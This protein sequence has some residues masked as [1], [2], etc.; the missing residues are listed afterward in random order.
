M[1]KDN[2][3]LV[4]SGAKKSSRINRTEGSALAAGKNST[5][6]DTSS[7]TRGLKRTSSALLD[8]TDD[9]HTIVC[10]C[11]GSYVNDKFDPRTGSPRLKHCNTAEHIKW[12]S[13]GRT[14]NNMYGS[15][16]TKSQVWMPGI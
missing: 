10:G 7:T 15:N 9:P 8:P 2:D 5:T 11:G 16:R 14:K 4:A 1:G 12:V 6:R 3:R 13:E